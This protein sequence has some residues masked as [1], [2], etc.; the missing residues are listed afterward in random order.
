M[1]KYNHLTLTLSWQSFVKTTDVEKGE[2]RAAVLSWNRLTEK[3]RKQPKADYPF[4]SLSRS[5]GRDLEGQQSESPR[6]SRIYTN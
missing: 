2:G 5:F 1:K 4:N 3:M 6:I